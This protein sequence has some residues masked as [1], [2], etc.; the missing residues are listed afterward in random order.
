MSAGVFIHESDTGAKGVRRMQAAVFSTLP[1]PRSDL[2]F[3][4]RWLVRPKEPMGC[5]G[6]PPSLS[7]PLRRRTLNVRTMDAYAAESRK[8]TNMR[9]FGPLF[10][11]GAMQAAHVKRQILADRASAI[12][13]PG[14]LF[15]SPESKSLGNLP[16][17]RC[18]IVRDLHRR[19]IAS[20]PKIVAISMLP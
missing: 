15:T 13:S 18:R 4:S 9:R 12:S 10:L 14:H 2:A 6:L 5:S 7:R 19:I 1:P 11:P 17:C 16:F 20:T 3:Y 8:T